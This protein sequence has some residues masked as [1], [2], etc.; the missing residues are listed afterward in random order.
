LERES[1]QIRIISYN[2]GLL[3]YCFQP[4]KKIIYPLRGIS[5]CSYF[6]KNLLNANDNMKISKSALWGKINLD[7][8]SRFIQ[9][10][11]SSEMNEEDIQLCLNLLSI[12]LNNMPS[13]YKN[14]KCIFICIEMVFFLYFL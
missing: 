8:L 9:K 3:K 14:T 6:K 5:N 11:D 13:V 10:T 7:N 4:K 12:N 2:T 1:L